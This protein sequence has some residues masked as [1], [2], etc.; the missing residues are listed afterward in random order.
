MSHI[1][2]K[3]RSRETAAVAPLTLSPETLAIP[4]PQVQTTT[5][6]VDNRNMTPAY[7]A[8]D[9]A[10]ADRLLQ[11]FLTDQAAKNP[12]PELEVDDAP[13]RSTRIRWDGQRVDVVEPNAP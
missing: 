10:H 11:Q 5:I 1:F 8:Q 7:S 3:G 9:T 13:P 2:L 4:K 6:P 12:P